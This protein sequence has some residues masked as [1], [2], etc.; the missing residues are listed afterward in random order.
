[1]Q[2]KRGP[3]PK[4]NEGELIAWMDSQADASQA[5]TMKDIKEHA[6]HMVKP[7]LCGVVLRIICKFGGK[8]WA[9]FKNRHKNVVQE[10]QPLQTPHKCVVLL[11]ECSITHI[12]LEAIKE[13]KALGVEVVFFP[14]HPTNVIQPLRKAVGRSLKKSFKRH[15]EKWKT[16]HNHQALALSDFVC[17]WATAFYDTVIPKNIL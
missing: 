7:R 14:P 9:S 17:F 4:L 2:L 5:P 13:L 11:L 10:V 3:K 1:M 16:V 15:E 12:S 6:K 8:W